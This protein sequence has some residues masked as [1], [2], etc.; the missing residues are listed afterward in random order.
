MS[1]NVFPR[2][3]VRETGCFEIALHTRIPFRYGITTMTEVPH[4]FVRVGLEMNGRMQQ[5]VAADCLPPKWFT[6]NPATTFEADLAEMRSV[7]RHACTAACDAGPAG[8]VFE[9]WT[10]LFDAQRIWSKERGL[11]PLLSGFGVSL[12]ERAV[13][14]AFCRATGT[15]FAHALRENTFGIRLAAINRDLEGS[16]PAQFLPLQ[17]LRTLQVRHTVGLGDP[18]SDADIP[19]AER[20]LDGLPQSLEAC[21]A[22]YG[23]THFK[24][25]LGGD[26]ETD[27]ARLNQLA[28]LLRRSAPGFAFTLDGNENY[29]A[30]A[31]FRALWEKLRSDAATAGFLKHLL[32]VEQPF[33]RDGA[34]AE[35]TAAELQAW[36]ERPPIIIDESDAEPGSLPAALTAG[37]IG[38]SYKN[39][40]GVFRGIANACLIAQLRRENASLQMSAEDLI[41]LGPVALLQDL[42]VVAALGIPHVERNGHHYFRGLQQF[43]AEVQQQVVDSHPDLYATHPAGFPTLRIASGR[44]ETGSVI[45]AP[46]G[47]A[48]NLNLNAFTAV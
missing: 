33:H 41:N 13:I 14:D 46:F 44:I 7:I 3:A 23:L 42:A 18:L 1:A 47:A 22:R 16:L 48:F 34:L 37:Y 40:K 2:M 24:I 29:H 35:K 39:C 19:P 32:F 10:R 31:P 20:L 11:P 30:V 6:K 38:T 8:S 45:A 26:M 5:G 9:L 4:L 12:V 15:P 43:P 27:R 36:S 28:A 25:K 17:P 21:I